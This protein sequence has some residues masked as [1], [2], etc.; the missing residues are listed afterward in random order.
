MPAKM[1][2]S[3]RLPPIGAS[4]VIAVVRAASLSCHNEGNAPKF[5]RNRGHLGNLG[6][7]VSSAC[8]F[9]LVSV[10]ADGPA[11]EETGMGPGPAPTV[12]V[13]EHPANWIEWRSAT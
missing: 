9:L 2:R 3:D 1:A 8:G 6:L 7:K 13:L 10:L 12:R 5:T 11:S 4:T